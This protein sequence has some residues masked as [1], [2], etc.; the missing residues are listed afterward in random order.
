MHELEITATG[1]RG[2]CQISR[3]SGRSPRPTQRG[4]VYAVK[5]IR[6]LSTQLRRFE[7]YLH[8]ARRPAIDAC[9][10]LFM[11]HW[12][13]QIFVFGHRDLVAISNRHY[14]R[15]LAF[16]CSFKFQKRCLHRTSIH[17]ILSENF[18]IKPSLEAVMHRPMICSLIARKQRRRDSFSPP[19]EV[20]CFSS[21]VRLYR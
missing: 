19:G 4:S 6:L 15:G 12:S 13:L 17:Q 20:R 21:N 2:I 14:I 18:L 5:P 7:H 8:R 10:L 9:A 11:S 1:R 3:S 16:S